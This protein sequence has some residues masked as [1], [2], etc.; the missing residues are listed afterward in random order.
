MEP[1]PESGRPTELRLDV[2]GRAGGDA[3]IAVHGD[4]DMV[5]SDDFRETVMRLVAD[6]A[7]TRVT[8]DAAELGFIDSN[9]VTV[10][11]KAHRAAGER[12]IPFAVANTQDPIRGLLEML[13]VYDLL[14]GAPARG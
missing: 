9:G 8:V 6:P 13:G 14:T 5:T 12:S 3:C 10:L 4:I 11:V 7:V 1:L 2:T